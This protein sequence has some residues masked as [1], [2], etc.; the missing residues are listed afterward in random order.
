MIEILRNSKKLSIEI[1]P[2]LS[3]ILE[4]NQKNYYTTK[5]S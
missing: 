4:L 1:R 5:Y 2:N 3:Y